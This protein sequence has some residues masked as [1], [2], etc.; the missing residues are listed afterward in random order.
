MQSVRVLAVFLWV[1]AA[2]FSQDPSPEKQARIVPLFR[3]ARQAEQQRDFQQ[4][5]RLYDKILAIDPNL[6]EVWNNKGLV[7]Y[8]LDRHR[9]ALPAFARAV[10]LKPELINPYLFLGIEY[11]KL[12]EPQKAVSPLRR[13]LA[14]QP[15]H[16]QASYE[17]AHAYTELEEFEPAIELYSPLRDFPGGIRNIH[18]H[19]C[20]RV[21]ELELRH[22]AGNC[23]RSSAVVHGGKTMV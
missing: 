14:L 4:A 8:Q 9:E 23:Y 7:L 22:D 11:L 13:V 21:H 5:A 1:I 3:Q 16:P 19:H 18:E 20:V 12:G 10:A 2:A 6:A 17:L 15:Y